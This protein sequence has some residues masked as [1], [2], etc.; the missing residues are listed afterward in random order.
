MFR[1]IWKATFGAALVLAA[2]VGFEGGSAHAQ[3]AQ[4]TVEQLRNATYPSEFTLSKTASLRDGRYDQRAALGPVDGPRNPAV[5][6]F[7]SAALGDGYAAV[8]L[9]TNTGGSGIF[10]TLHLV[11]YEAGAVQAG[12]GLFLGD[13]WQINSFTAQGNSVTLDVVRTAPTDPL[14]CPTLKDTQTY[15]RDANAFRLQSSTAASTQPAPTPPATGSAGLAAGGMGKFAQF[16]LVMTVAA[17]ALVAR[18]L[19]PAR[20]AAPATRVAR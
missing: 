2:A 17:L 20:A 11:T 16:V 13:R 7:H 6:M 1:A 9:T 10:L 5:V 12:P 8:L 3:G 15:V 18:R 19:T 14:C 4:V